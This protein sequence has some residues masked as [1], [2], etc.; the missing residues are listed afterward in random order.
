MPRYSPPGENN[1]PDAEVEIKENQIVKENNGLSLSTLSLADFQ[2][3]LRPGHGVEGTVVHLRTNYFKITINPG[4]KLFKYTF[5]LTAKYKEPSKKDAPKEKPKQPLI[6]PERSRKRRQALALLLQHSD[7]R[8]IGHGVAT[9]YGTIIITSKE[10]PLDDDGTKEYN[11]V[12]REVEDREPAS[13]PI[14]YTFTISYLGLV[15]TTELLRYLASTPTDPSDFTGKDDAIQALNI[16]VAR[17]PNFN[18]GVFQSGN[19]KFFHYPTDPSTYD[20]LGGGLIAVRG[21]Y[22]SVRTSTLRILL[23]VNAQTSPFYPAVN[24]LDLIQKHGRDD[25]IA[26]ENFLHLLRVRTKYMKH[27]DGTEEVKVKTIYGFSQQ[28]DNVLDSKGKVITDKK[29]K[30]L[31]RRNLQIGP[32]DAQHVSFECEEFANK[33]FTIEEYFKEKYNI[34]LRLPQAWLLNC[35]T[36]EKPVWIPPE[37]CEVMPGQAF[38]GKLTEY[39]TSQMILVAAR[40]PGENARRIANGA[41]RVIGYQGNN[42]SLAAF[43]VGVDPKMIVIK[44]RILPAPPVTYRNNSQIIPAD[45]SWNMRGKEFAI[46]VKVTKWSFLKLGGVN[47]G[48]TYLDMFKKALK[49]YG[50]GTEGPSNP[51][52]FVAPLPGS[53]DANDA[54]I[55]KVFK[56]MF[57]AKLKMV[58]VILPAKSAVTYARVKYYGDVMAGIHTVCVLSENLNRGLQYYANVALKF[59]LKCGGVNQL[60]PTQLGFLHGGDAMVV[61][62]DVSHPAP[63]SMEGTP[64]IA[65]V[66]ASVDDRYGQW[67]GSI[68]PQESKKE[69]V[70]TLSLMMQERLKL[71]I[72]TNKRLPSKILIYRDGVSEGQYKT[73]LEDELKQIREACNEIY[74]TR[75]LPKITIVVVGKR[76]HTR[77]YPTNATAA[78][79][80]GNPV[81][82]TVVDRGVTMEKGCKYFQFPSRMVQNHRVGDMLPEL[83]TFLV[84]YHGPELICTDQVNMRT[85]ESADSTIVDFFLQA[86]AALQGTAKPS[87]YVVI[88][89]EMKLGA[90]ELQTITHHL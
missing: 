32:L 8:S 16:I 59:N 85:K 40:G 24:V 28:W 76:H 73:V 2:L 17:T 14:I 12:Y 78:D 38:R 15:P 45:A 34:T 36:K 80:K 21:Y 88:L 3:P 51:Q 22:S 27:N 58:L 25:R 83:N 5:T 37:L 90:E 47:F 43:G 35:G 72:S 33:T 49:D 56:I 39:Q 55:E 54:S 41:H 77:F 52:G 67:P 63:K 50:L 69:M 19:N 79:S 65:A 89:D 62:I 48:N 6:P 66:V 82:G 42:P 87:H 74:G 26:L 1:R 4:K 71:W 9:D 86:H 61:G 30:V 18:P 64:S 23:N 68:R 60:L 53:E 57:Q 84:S 81:N 20:D 46:P 75:T 29:G 10:L 44:G 31:Q 13:N 70:S 11:V 7:F